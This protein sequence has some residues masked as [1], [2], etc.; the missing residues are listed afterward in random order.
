[1]QRQTSTAPTHQTST[2]KLKKSI[3]PNV[4]NQSTPLKERSKHKFNS[5]RLIQYE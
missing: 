5:R 1:M 4:E 2:T 3:N